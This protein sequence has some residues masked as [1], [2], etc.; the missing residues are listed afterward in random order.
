MSTA[1]HTTWSMARAQSTA[2][3]LSLTL[4]VGAHF[5]LFA[6]DPAFRVAGIGFSTAELAAIEIPPDVVIPPA[7]ASI[8]RPAIPVVAT[9]DVDDNITI[10]PTTFEANPFSSIAAPPTMTRQ[11]EDLRAAPQF[12]PYNVKPELRN[13]DA[14]RAHLVRAYPAML[15]DAGIGGTVLLWVFIDESGTVQRAVVHTSS[16]YATLDDAALRVAPE[17]QFTPA[18]YRDRRVPVWIEL[19]LFFTTK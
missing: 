18:I 5:A 9:T 17:M 10:A 7:P 19:P 8:A 3:A 2:F 4:S 14:V 1:M 11:E 15:R 12:T 6:W 16:G 13:S